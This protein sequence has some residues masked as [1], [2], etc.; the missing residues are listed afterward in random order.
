M[1]IDRGA[2]RCKHIRMRTGLRS[3][4]APRKVSSR[5]RRDVELSVLKPRLSHLRSSF[6][7]SRGPCSSHRVVLYLEGPLRMPLNARIETETFVCSFA[8]ARA[9]VVLDLSGVP[10]IDA[11]GVGELVARLQPDHGSR[12]CAAG[13][14]RDGMGSQNSRARRAVRH[15]QRRRK[16]GG[17]LAGAVKSI[18]ARRLHRRA[19]CRGAGI[20]Q[21]ALNGLRIQRH[22]CQT[23]ATEF[24]SVPTPDIVIRTESCASSVNES[25]GTTP[26]PVS[27]I[28]PFGNFWDR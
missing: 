9:V 3:G 10:R 15:P 24:W 27:R 20:E 2:A 17:H 13:C 21:V 16:S 1:D 22:G 5:M 19:A 11:A 12:P 14:G 23:I 18:H 6:G 26:A 7:V 8:T 25:G 4:Q 28:A